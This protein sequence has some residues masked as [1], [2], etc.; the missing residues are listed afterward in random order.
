MIYHIL[1]INNI[2]ILL[3]DTILF[4]NNKYAYNN[5]ITPNPILPLPAH[6]PLLLTIPRPL[7]CFC[8]LSPPHP[9]PH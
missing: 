8:P 3:F 6:L 1:C 4:C 2:N 5:I 7:P 9:P